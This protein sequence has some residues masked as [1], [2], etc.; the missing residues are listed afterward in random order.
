[1]RKK[2]VFLVFLVFYITNIY[3][4]NSNISIKVCDSVSKKPLPY[5][6]VY[7]KNKLKGTMTNENGIA[8]FKNINNFTDTIICSYIGYK[9][10]KIPLN[11]KHYNYT[12]KLKNIDY[13]ISSITVKYKTL[14]KPEII[15]KKAINS[16]KTNYYTKPIVLNGIYGELVFEEN[17][18]IQMNEAIFNLY[19]TGYTQKYDKNIWEDWM[20]DYTHYINYY[21]THSLF[22]ECQSFYTSFNTKKEKLD[23]I[24]VRSSDNLSKYNIETCPRGGVLSMTSCDK[25]KYLTDFLYKKNFNLYHYKTI[26]T[27]KIKDIECFVIEFFPKNNNKEMIFDL[28]KKLNKAIFTGRLFIDK[29][30]YSM[31]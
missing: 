13:K 2:I 9:T 31:W 27:T 14:P 12:A 10:R 20:Y 18:C 4:Q 25:V 29:K 6:T 1:M 3:S 11:I 15:L 30:T 21:A 22:G 19:Y 8:I 7:L 23:I 28:G 5:A 24:T 16:I 17:K 26:G